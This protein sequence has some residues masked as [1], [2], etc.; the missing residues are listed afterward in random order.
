MMVRVVTSTLPAG[1]C[2]VVVSS[3]PRQ[4][5]ADGRSC[6]AC[7]MHARRPAP[8]PVPGSASRH[9]ES[10]AAGVV[11][12]RL[13]ATIIP[14]AAATHNRHRD[15]LNTILRSALLLGCAHYAYDAPFALSRT[16]RL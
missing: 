4:N 1:S 7:A 6:C 14:A 10:A 16:V 13:V 15:V 2:A 8:S 3:P 11:A 12:T 9:P 5:Q